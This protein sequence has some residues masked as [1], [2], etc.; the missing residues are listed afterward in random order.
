MAKYYK[1]YDAEI[2]EAEAG[3][4][5]SYGGKPVL[6]I[7]TKENVATIL[8][9]ICPKNEY[10]NTYVTREWYTNVVQMGYVFANRLYAEDFICCLKNDELDRVKAA[11]VEDLHLADAI[12][13][14]ASLPVSVPMDVELI[15]ADLVVEEE[16]LPEEDPAEMDLDAIQRELLEKM[17]ED[18]IAQLLVQFGAE[19]TM[20]YLRMCH[21]LSIV[22]KQATD[23]RIFDEEIAYYKQQIKSKI[24][25]LFDKS[26]DNRG[27][28]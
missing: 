25:K 26:D 18:E 13:M 16:E 24:W 5:Y 23:D 21:F 14:V 8:H 7:A 17:H 11:I 4:I 28:E 6:V 20:K 2:A 9:L 1:N 15:D 22:R 12:D 10:T 19:D 3:E 27:E